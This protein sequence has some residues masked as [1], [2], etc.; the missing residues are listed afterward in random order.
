MSASPTKVIQTF[1]SAGHYQ[2]AAPKAAIL[3]ALPAS[4]DRQS[5]GADARTG[6][7]DR[8]AGIAEVMHNTANTSAAGKSD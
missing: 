3:Q 7:G 4:M 2:F 1:V 8:S 5:D 6:C